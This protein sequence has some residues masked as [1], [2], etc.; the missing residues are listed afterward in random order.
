MKLKLLLSVIVGSTAVAMQP[1]QPRDRNRARRAE[2]EKVY[3]KYLR[4]EYP[5]DNKKTN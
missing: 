4:D 2:R 5:E 1:V 3:S